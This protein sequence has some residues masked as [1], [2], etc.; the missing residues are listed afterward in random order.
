MVAPPTAR[1]YRSAVTRPAAS[2]VRTAKPGSINTP[3]SSPSRTPLLAGA[4]EMQPYEP[5]S[6]AVREDPYPYYA[7]LRDQAPVYWAKGA[8]AWCV[9]RYDDVHFVLCNPELFSS[10]AMR[11][12]LMGARPGVNLLEDP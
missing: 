11:T 3:N 1:T 12:M 8:Q 10:D 5:F 2:A 6:D 4:A 9:S 7:A